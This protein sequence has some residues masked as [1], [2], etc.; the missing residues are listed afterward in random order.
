MNGV[1]IVWTTT[2]GDQEHEERWP[3]LPAFL[4]WADR[5]DLHGTFSAYEDDEGELVVVEK[6]RF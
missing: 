4:A 3:S 5:E 1:I 6:G 2:A